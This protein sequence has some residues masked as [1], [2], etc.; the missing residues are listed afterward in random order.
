MEKFLWWSLIDSPAA[1]TPMNSITGRGLAY[2]LGWSGLPL[3]DMGLALLAFFILDGAN[4]LTGQQREVLARRLR[5][6]LYGFRL[7]IGWG[8]LYHCD[9]PQL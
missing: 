1:L 6:R 9:E 4:G 2:D 8:R 7:N 3:F 5:P